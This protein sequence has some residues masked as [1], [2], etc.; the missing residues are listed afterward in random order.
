LGT[1]VLDRFAGIATAATI[2]VVTSCVAL[3]GVLTMA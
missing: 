3:L 2:A 1:H